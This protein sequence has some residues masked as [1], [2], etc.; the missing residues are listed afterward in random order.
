MS[1]KPARQHFLENYQLFVVQT[2]LEHVS[3][4]KKNVHIICQFQ[5]KKVLIEYERLKFRS[6][7]LKTQIE[8][9]NTG[10]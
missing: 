9:A 6:H 3:F 4:K 5:E 2:Y 7:Q 10:R 1:R 8:N